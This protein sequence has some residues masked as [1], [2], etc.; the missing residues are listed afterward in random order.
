[1]RLDDGTP[2]PGAGPLAR[3]VAANAMAPML[4]LF[5]LI[6]TGG[7]R[8]ALYAGPGRVLRVELQQ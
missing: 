3:H 5:D 1:A 4:P 6:A 2:T 8:V 7:E